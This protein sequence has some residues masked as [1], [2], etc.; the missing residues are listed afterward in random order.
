MAQMEKELEQLQ[1]KIIDALEAHKEKEA[2]ALGKELKEMR[3][4][5]EAKK[6]LKELGK[7]AEARKELKDKAAVVIKKVSK[8]TKA[9]DEFLLK[10]DTLIKQLEPLIEPFKELAKLQAAAWER[11]PGECYLFN[12]IGAFAA[13]IEKIPK[14]YF[15]EGF[16][17]SFIRMKG[18]QVDAMG[19][20]EESLQ[21]FSAALGILL[22]FEKGESKIPLQKA[23]GL[24]SLFDEAK[25]KAGK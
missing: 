3:A 19:K 25:G 24:M 23:E 2:E 8:Q 1:K 12:D 14:D 9:I 16:G 6:E 17:C 20:A 18:D 4:D 10:R 15:S 5:I 11:E 22:A 21:Y 13:A 7:I